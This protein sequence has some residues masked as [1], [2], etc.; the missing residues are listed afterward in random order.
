M[1]DSSG[2]FAAGTI[3]ASLSGTASTA[4]AVTAGNGSVGAVV[5]IGQT[6]LTS[7]TSSKIRI[8]QTAPTAGGAV[9]DIWI[10]Y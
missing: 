7:P 9:G 6:N 2:N 8:T 5:T 3:T 4:S 10:V 1:R